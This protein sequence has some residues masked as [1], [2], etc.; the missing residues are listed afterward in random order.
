MKHILYAKPQTLT[1]TEEHKIVKRKWWAV[2]LLIIGGIIL[3]GRLP[4]PLWIPYAFFFFGPAGQLADIGTGF[5][6][7]F[8][9][10]IHREKNHR[11]TRITQMTAHSHGDHAGF[12]L[13]Q[14]S[15]TRAPALY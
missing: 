3:A 11:A 8:V 5:D 6:D 15:G 4:V 7:A 12:R 14:A 1:E 13:Q 9:A 10:E 2:V